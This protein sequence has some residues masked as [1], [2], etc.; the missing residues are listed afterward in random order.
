MNLNDLKSFLTDENGLKRLCK[1]KVRESVSLD[2]KQT[3][4]GKKD[5]DKIEA[6][7][8]VA[9]FANAGCPGYILIGIEDKD[10]I[11]IDVPGIPDSENELKRLL[12]LEYLE[13]QWQ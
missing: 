6:C 3:G 9:S 1:E 5:S 12:S 4:Y 11:A 7:K 10:S 8:D 2:I 13:H